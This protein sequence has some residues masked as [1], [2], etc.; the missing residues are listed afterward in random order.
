MADGKKDALKFMTGAIKEW[1]EV[2]SDRQK[3][4]GEVMANEMKAKQNWFY[5]LQEMNYQT[6]YQKQLGEQYQKQQGGGQVGGQGDALGAITQPRVE[7]GAKGYE[8]DEPSREAVAYGRL[9][10]KAQ[11]G[12]LSEEEDNMMQALGEKLGIKRK[13]E[14]IYQGT[15]EWK[16]KDAESE[17]LD[18]YMK[19]IYP[20]VSK[21]EK[22]INYAGP[23]TSKGEVV[24]RYQE[25]KPV[26]TTSKGFLDLGKTLGRLDKTED[27]FQEWAFQN[28]PDLARQAFPGQAQIMSK[29][30]T[31]EYKNEKDIN[32]AIDSGDIKDGD[33]I[34]IDG[35]KQRIKLK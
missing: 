8:Q 27:D 22:W 11:K 2:Q 21:G 9:N 26:D 6:P 14:G 31:K 13:G 19:S 25:G 30:K 5:K 24:R 35:K 12:Q 4:M 3:I 23:M 18:E 28:Y 34:T 33:I 1:S 15:A 10:M 32:S 20:E 16:K 29:Q 17:L 7:M